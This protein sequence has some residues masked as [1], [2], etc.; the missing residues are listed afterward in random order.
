MIDFKSGD[1]G[2]STDK[3]FL[4]NT[5]RFFESIWTKNANWSHAFLFITPNTIIES[6]VKITK[7]P[8]SKYDKSNINIYRLPLSNKVRFELTKL[9]DER[10]G[11]AYGWD[12]YPLFILDCTATWFKQHIL[13]QKKPCFFFTSTFKI[14]NI[15][16]CSQLVVWGIYKVSS[17]RFKDQYGDEVD[18]R[19]ITPDVLEDL[20]KL[21]INKAKL[22][23]QQEAK[24][25]IFTADHI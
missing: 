17:Y 5:I 4:G 14:S 16:V 13:N 3:S 21:P 19:I 7:S 15:P 25:R 12:K 20:L 18:W 1:I 11:G 8:K 2:L 9:M 22:I 10:E 6:L 24:C 23:Y